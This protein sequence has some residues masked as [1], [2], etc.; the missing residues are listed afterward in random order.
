[1][2]AVIPARPQIAHSGVSEGGQCQMCLTE[3]PEAPWCP[4]RKCQ[5]LLSAPQGK[6]SVQVFSWPPIIKMVVLCLIAELAGFS[7]GQKSQPLLHSCP[8]R[9][10]INAFICVYKEKG[11]FLFLQMAWVQEIQSAGVGLE[12]I[13]PLLTPSNDINRESPKQGTV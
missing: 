3:V 12:I 13:L 8:R 1:M 5:A 10:S 6:E 4:L 2:S 11:T 7:V 9:F